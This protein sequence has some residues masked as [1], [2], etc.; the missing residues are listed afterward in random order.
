MIKKLLFLFAFFFSF[1]VMAQ[2]ISNYKHFSGRY[3]F[4]MIG[5][6]L[7]SAPNGTG[8][9]CT[10]LTQSS[11][12]LN[13]L[14]TQTVEAAYLYWSGSGS[15][16]Q[17][18]LNVK[19]NGTA[20]TSQRTF[21]AAPSGGLPFFGAFADVTALVKSTGSSTY[22]LSDFDISSV[23]A[24]YCPTGINYAGWSMIVIYEDLSLTNRV[25]SVFDGFEIVDPSNQNLSFTLNGLNVTSVV[26]SKVGFL[27][28]EGDDNI[29]V[30]EELRINNMLVSNPPLNPVNNTFNSTNTFTGSSSL[31]NMDLDYY[32]I[33][34]YVSVGDT[35]LNVRIR[36]GQDLII[37]NSF[38]VTL[39]SVFA[40]ATIKL[41]SF[42]SKCN[43]R[44]VEIAYTV[45]NMNSTNNL[46]A[47][48]P[49]AFYLG[50]KLI[51]ST[52]TK[53]VIPI[54]GSESGTVLLTID[55]EAPDDFSIRARVDDDGFGKGI[56]VE[57][58]EENNEAETD[59]HLIRGPKIKQPGDVVECDVDED[60]E[61]VFDLTFKEDE[62]INAG[63]DLVV[64][65]FENE[66]DADENTRAITDTRNYTVKVH[67]K[68]RIW[69]RVYNKHNACYSV[70]S[71]LITA[72]EKVFANIDQPIVICNRKNDATF[73]DLTIVEWL[74]RKKYPYLDELSLHFYKSRSDADAELNEILELVHY[75][76]SAFPEFI[77]LKAKGK[78]VLWCD[79]IVEIKIN[80]CLIPKGISPNGDASNDGFDLT[81]F[82]LIQL[83]IF[84]RYGM[85]VYTHGEGYTDQWKGQDKNGGILPSG[86]YFYIFKTTFDTY[87]GYVHVIRETR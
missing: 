3:D 64:T 45:F 55:E 57:L 47:N 7:N 43:D 4:T 38:I 86:T 8:S 42:K 30:S 37:A 50:D 72:Q 17:A 61:I 33:S 58:N 79:N 54:D 67:T 11:A 16:Q 15:L 68:K 18:D 62:I 51:G 85:E 5:N 82:N 21:T 74:L 39:S 69:V 36:S 23:I 78:S 12:V 28:W 2:P 22:L 71:F 73:A 44:E 24:P 84:N 26:G 46:I 52:K 10:V 65:Y 35:S 6:T 66:K 19:L 1:P 31:W 53:G 29:A 56:I 27:T 87:T 40:D 59:V 13:L 41:D 83:Q 49:I 34:S 25:V 14:P 75:R 63:S 32:L 80:D 9:P 81:N 70:T 20:I 48:T 77:Y 60:G 76:P